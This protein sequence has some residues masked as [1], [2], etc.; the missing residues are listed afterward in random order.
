MKYVV[1][2]DTNPCEIV[3]SGGYMCMRWRA[4]SSQFSPDK[5]CHQVA[6]TPLR[7]VPGHSWSLIGQW[8]TNTAIVQLTF[9]VRTDVQAEEFVFRYV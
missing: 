7:D 4:G 6:G 1:I 3:R 8:P 9:P 2:V 5:Y